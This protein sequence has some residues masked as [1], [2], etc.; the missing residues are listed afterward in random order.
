MRR[1]SSTPLPLR[2]RLTLRRVDTPGLNKKYHTTSTPPPGSICT[3]TET[4]S[5]SEPPSYASQRHPTTDSADNDARSEVTPS[6]STSCSNHSETP[7]IEI[8]RHFGDAD[9]YWK[10]YDMLADGYRKDM[11]EVLT[12]DLD[13]TLLF[14]A[15]F[16]AVDTSLIV[17][18]CAMLSAPPDAQTVALLKLIA[19]GRTNL[20]DADLQPP[21]FVPPNSAIRINCFFGISLACCLIS[22]F[23]AMLAKQWVAHFACNPPGTLEAQGR[24]RQRQFN[25]SAKWR[26]QHVVELLPFTLQI[27]LATF[28]AG[29]IDG[30]HSLNWVVTVVVSVFCLVGVMLFCISVVMATLYP[31]CPFQSPLTVLLRK[32]FIRCHR[33]GSRHGHRIRTAFGTKP[34]ASGSTPVEGEEELGQKGPLTVVITHKSSDS[35]T[36][37]ECSEMAGDSEDHAD[38]EDDLINTYCASWVMESF[39]HEEALLSTSKNIPALRTIRGTRLGRGGLA[40]ARLMSLFRDALTTWKTSTR[41]GWVPAQSRVALENTLVHG[42]ALG[43]CTTGGRSAISHRRS[44]KAPPRAIWPKWQHKSSGNDVN[45]VLLLKFC[46]VDN[47]P[48]GFCVTHPK[49]EFPHLSTALHVYLAAIV[50]PSLRTKRFCIAACKLDRITLVQW[51]AELSFT[52]HD[53]SSPTILSIAAWSLA[54]LPSMISS[55]DGSFTE[56]L[57]HE[58]WDAYTT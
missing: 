27:A 43:H 33:F 53:V 9:E 36:N 1:A 24:W 8:A 16:S 7:Q 2:R 58:W 10:H 35:D 20:T 30:L 3:T 28:V 39:E 55:V 26:L 23:G 51:L 12:N 41:R 38:G 25:G 37:E 15:L 44:P 34:N 45:E 31:E 14:A 11:V 49:S 57:R 19:L 54:K 50:K 42:R 22:A 6:R 47:V 17:F 5:P 4:S 52:S 46:L 56:E 40:H 13:S 48:P 18:T 21:L 32:A 29:V